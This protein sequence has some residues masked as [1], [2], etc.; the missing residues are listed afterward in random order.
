LYKALDYEENAVEPSLMMVH[1]NS[2]IPPL[3][4][5]PFPKTF[6]EPRSS[7][8]ALM[9][10]IGAVLGDIFGG[11]LLSYLGQPQE[12]GILVGT[13]IGAAIGAIISLYLSQNDKIRKRLLILVGTAAAVDTA[14][15]VA[16]GA[17]MPGFLLGGK[18]SFI[19]R[20]GL[21]L[22]LSLALFLVKAKP[23]FDKGVW[24]QSLD[25]S[26]D[27]FLHAIVP[28]SAVLMFRL[29]ERKET[30]DTV[31]ETKL[32]KDIVPLIR[33]LKDNPLLND[34]V[35]F[36]QIVQKIENA[37]FDM[38]PLASRDSPAI[39]VWEQ[40]LIERYNTFGYI[41]LGQKVI[42]EEEPLIKDGEVIKKGLV[43][44]E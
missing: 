40:S 35:L 32:I 37:G 15:Q 34:E 16:K 9:S 14:I 30:Y 39:L 1:L 27:A 4:L 42:V 43:A 31:D 23:G 2:L 20:L 24:R 41:K 7:A 44:P 25:S 12:T 13:A 3:R 29:K 33:K 21:Y 26:I 38:T 36:S 8:V 28:L 10:A 11:A 5:P 22:A 19:K 17:L 18:G 6:L